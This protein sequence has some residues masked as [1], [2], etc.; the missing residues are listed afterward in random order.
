MIAN[1]SDPRPRC[2]SIESPITSPIAGAAIS[3]L[4]RSIV[5]PV[6]GID[7]GEDFLDL[8]VLDEAAKALRLAR[9]AVA[10]VEENIIANADGTRAGIADDAG[11]I[12][13]LARRLL[14]A[15]PE[16]GVAGAIVLIDS[17]RWPRDLD[18]VMRAPG[19][20]LRHGCERISA[21][22]AIDIALRAIVRGLVLKKGSPFRLALF[23]TPKFEFFSACASD[24][25]CKPHLAAIARELFGT[26]LE[27]APAMAAPTGGRLFT[28]FMLTGFAAYRALE[29]SPAARFEAYPDLAF[30]LWARGVEIPPKRAG[31]PALDARKRINRRL[32]DEMGCTGAC[33]ISTLDQADAAVLALS[34]GLAARAGVVA[35]I[36]QPGEG[37]FALALDREQAR[38]GIERRNLSQHKAI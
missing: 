37:R 4:T 29:R 12:F 34:A 18:L 31:W 35:I 33:A 6:I 22:R 7:V 21:S 17:P 32:A 30:R 36:E 2:A 11:A 9:V 15:V 28:R 24:P 1:P 3:S 25:R 16:F 26:A 19:A 14:A 20:P 27:G 23:P 10:G 8:A 5:G 13:E 38:S